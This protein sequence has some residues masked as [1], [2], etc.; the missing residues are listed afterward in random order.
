[1]I[2][3]L[4][5]VYFSSRMF[6]FL[7]RLFNGRSFFNAKEFALLFLGIVLAVRNASVIF[8]I[9][10][11]S[12]AQAKGQQGAPGDAAQKGAL[13]SYLLFTIVGI[14]NQIHILND[15]FVST[16]CTVFFE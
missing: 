5:K 4:L 1:M 9:S 15:A 13:C 7:N 6:F 2:F 14:V 10:G 8:L 3:N 12:Q 11:V 16:G